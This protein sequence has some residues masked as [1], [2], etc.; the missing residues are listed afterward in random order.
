MSKYQS[1]L[2]IVVV[3]VVLICG[4][5]ALR[6]HEIGT[7]RV[8]I[9]VDNTGAYDVGVI[10]DAAALA[11]KL[12]TVAGRTL[13]ADSSATQLSD[14]L[15][16][17]RTLLRQRMHLTFAGPAVAGPHEPQRDVEVQPEIHISV[18]PPT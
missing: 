8:T 6:A 12:E 17:H 10:T 14:V 3:V 15:T 16:A 1:L 2:G 4:T 9:V 7:T 11:E 13:P 18:V 5:A